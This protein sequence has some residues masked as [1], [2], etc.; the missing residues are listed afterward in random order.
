MA[1]KVSSDS[2]I[3]LLPDL[4]EGL[5]EAEII[6]WCVKVGQR[7][8]EFDTI[9]KMETDKAMV[10]VPADRSGTIDALHGRPGEKVKVGAPLVTYGGGSIQHNGDNP[11]TAAT[12]RTMQPEAH[13]DAEAKSDES[14]DAGTVVGSL[15]GTPM[16]EAEPGK[17]IATPA[18]RRIARDLGIELSTISGSGIGG[19]ITERD[20]RDAGPHANGTSHD[21][22]PAAEE[23]VARPPMRKVIERE[24]DS[25]PSAPPRP[26]EA[27]GETT[28]IPFLGIRRTIAERLRYSL[29]HAVH[30]C[31]MDEAD[32]GAL[33]ETRKKLAIASGEKVSFLPFVAAAVC[34]ILQGKYG[35]E[36][37]KINSVVDDDGKQ[38]VQHRSVHL[39]IATDTENGLVVPVIRGAHTLGILELQRKINTQ[40]KAAR[41]RSIARDQLT[42]STFTISNVGS[43]GGRFATPIVNYPESAILALG[44]A[45][46]GVVVRNRMMGVGKLLPLSLSC[47]H[48][49]IDGA[50]AASA[51]NKLIELLQNPDELMK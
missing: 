21:D 38:I 8:S 2:N 11:L 40:A 12:Q 32:V 25:R 31:V 3:F 44:R 1:G 7:V 46:D 42:G 50:T 23:P 13:P 51:L 20:V 9:A 29:D 26:V 41:E 48:R 33:D 6:E 28:R 39:G 5:D 35:L 19:R 24:V 43:V 4:G 34:K 49:V 47:D 18:V 22:E 17:V 30:F 27:P 16:I 36:F 15:K 37:A 14:E 45:R 10:E